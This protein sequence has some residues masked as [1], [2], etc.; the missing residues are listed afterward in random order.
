MGG[1]V[2]PVDPGPVPSVASRERLRT[3]IRGY[4]LSQAVYVATRLGIPDLLADGPREIDELAAG[5]EELVL[6]TSGQVNITWPESGR[7]VEQHLM[8]A[9]ERV[10]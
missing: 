2:D 1:H 4:R 6:R 3:L 8:K 9:V 5:T 7:L 10:P